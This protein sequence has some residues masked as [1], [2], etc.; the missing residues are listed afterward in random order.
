MVPPSVEMLIQPTSST[1]VLP[2]EQWRQ[3]ELHQRHRPL[4]ANDICL[5]P[6]STMN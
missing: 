5:I 3:S 6:D 1:L 2:S 4:Q